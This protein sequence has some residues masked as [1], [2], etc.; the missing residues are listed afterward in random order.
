MHHDEDVTLEYV[1]EIALEP[2]P[3]C[4]GTGLAVICPRRE[5]PDCHGTGGRPKI[6]EDGAIDS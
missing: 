1:G 6:A 2:C 3:T 5:C 4:H